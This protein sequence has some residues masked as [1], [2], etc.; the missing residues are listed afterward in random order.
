[1]KLI[2]KIIK[3]SQNPIATRLPVTTSQCHVLRHFWPFTARISSLLLPD[4][5]LLYAPWMTS[6]Y[7]LWCSLAPRLAYTLSPHLPAPGRLLIATPWMTSAHSLW[8]SFTPCL[9]STLSPPCKPLIT[10][11][12]TAHLTVEDTYREWLPLIH[13]YTPHAIIPSLLHLIVSTWHPVND[14]RSFTVV[15]RHTSLCLSNI[16]NCHTPISFMPTANLFA[17]IHTVNDFRSFTTIQLMLSFTL[18][19]IT[20]TAFLFN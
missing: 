12:H 9:V 6:T 18:C 4:R 7:S 17:M 16:P 3:S 11:M 14:S 20:M 19:P 1:M 13:H 15:I 8:W 5:L 2:I 10:F